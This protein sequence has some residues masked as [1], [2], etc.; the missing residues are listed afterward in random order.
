[1][2]PGRSPTRPAIRRS[3]SRTLQRA[4]SGRIDT[5]GADWCR[6]RQRATVNGVTQTTFY[7]GGLYK[8]VTE[9]SSDAAGA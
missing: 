5:T 3:R 4:A 7:I 8:K 6:F 2:P 1:M 9:G